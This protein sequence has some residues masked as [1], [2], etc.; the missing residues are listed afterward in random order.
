MVE[1]N[2]WLANIETRSSLNR[3]ANIAILTLFLFVWLA[4][5][6]LV[7]SPPLSEF[8]N[9]DVEAQFF[10]VEIV[11]YIGIT[12]TAH[13][14]GQTDV[15]RSSFDGP[16]SSAS[17]KGNLEIPD[18]NSNSTHTFSREL[19]TAMSDVASCRKIENFGLTSKLELD[20]HIIVQVGNTVSAIVN[21][22][23]L[24]S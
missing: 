15:L 12:A 20:G 23:V 19:E 16:F 21:L 14:F 24:N 22:D 3:R 6:I 11:V 7:S 8:W 9:S 4:C 2:E 10:D 18:G 5:L 17:G 1:V 13:T